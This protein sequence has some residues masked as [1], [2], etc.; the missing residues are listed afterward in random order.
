MSF[1]TM[2]IVCGSSGLQ[3]LDVS[4]CHSF[5][6]CGVGW[7][8]Q[9]GRGQAGGCGG[10]VFVSCSL[11]VQK[12]MPSAFRAFRAYVRIRQFLNDVSL[13]GFFWGFRYL[14]WLRV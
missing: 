8:E 9:F 14:L 7:D 3:Q 4:G 12:P 11:L 6:S 5:D 13:F 2:I 1:V 10:N